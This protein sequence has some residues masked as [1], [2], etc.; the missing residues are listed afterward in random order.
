MSKIKV[1]SE[2]LSNRIAAGEVIERP[3]SVV[4][5]LVEN[6]IDA[7]ARR[8]RIEIERAGSR[9]IAVSDDGCGM[10]GD[11]AMLSLEPHG[12]SKLLSEDDI[13]NI[14][15]LGFRG[16][17]LPSIASISRLTLTTRTAGQ[18][19][20]TQIVVEGGKLIDAGP[21]GGAV[22]T[23]IRVRDLF[24]NTPA[25]KKFL[26]ADATEAHHI[27]EAVLALA[28]PRPEVAFELVMDGRS[29]FHSPAA[30][31]AA[32]RLREF[33]GRVYADS[34]WPVSHRENGMEITGYIASPGFTRNSRREQRTF[35][36]GR[37]V[38]SLAIYRGI[39]DGY[40]T[41]AESGRFPPAILFLVMS[42]LDVDVNVHPAKREVRFKH[43]YAVSRAIAAA[44]GNA[45]KRTREAG[46]PAGAEGLP[47]SG[48]IPLRMVLDSAAV[49]YEPRRSEQPVMPEI[50]PPA[51]GQPSAEEYETTPPP[52]AATPP[53]G[54]SPA[55]SAVSSE[56]RPEPAENDLYV[57]PAPDYP[58]VP[59]ENAGFLTDT[60]PGTEPEAA[61]ALAV[62]SKF[63]YPDIPFNGEWPTGI[64]GV[65]DD[66]YLLAS[67]KTGLILI[68]QHAAHE[69]IMFERLL[70]AA[71]H[72]AASQALLL[73]QTLELPQTMASLLLRNRKI[74]E[75]VGFDVEP[76]GSNTVM[77]NAV[78]A[79]LPSS[80]ELTVM[81]PD[82]LQ[83][84]LDNLEH[85]LPVELEYVARAACRAA[86]KAHDAL[87]RQAAEELL[88]QLGE[89]RQG[90]LCPH[91]RPTM[92]TLTLREIEK[93]FARR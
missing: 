39:R 64:I 48:Q 59:N 69:R 12:T 11:D 14:V 77:L 67:G 63:D 34:L 91:G 53:A 74:F 2:Q 70:D 86:V 27:E 20:G 90:T 1:M 66:T 82:M 37:A 19:E 76:L 73:P 56:S 79:A 81:I 25:R 31:N 58:P 49:Q 17:A 5:E 41:L 3:A 18:L 7:G 4:K 10:D 57:S 78:P 32:P 42:P 68:D 44:V 93:R 33:F 62:R 84:L 26:K 61:A 22:G 71:R 16:E 9:L 46:P 88:R 51:P 50:I 54:L 52:Q 8:V 40:A 6:A 23:T 85:K 72:G 29:V 28:I 60:A 45:L 80:R 83:E 13:D 15:T 87:P 65:L 24:F 35:V 92:I 38:E 21:C 55:D 75:A 43:E 89:C 47:L 30:E 36:N